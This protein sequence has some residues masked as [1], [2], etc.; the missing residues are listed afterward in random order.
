[1]N[2]DRLCKLAAAQKPAR[3]RA[4]WAGLGRSISVKDRRFAPL[5]KLHHGARVD[6]LRAGSDFQVKRNGEDPRFASGPLPVPANVLRERSSDVLTPGQLAA[7]HSA[8]RARVIIGPSYRADMWAALEREPQLPAAELARRT[9]GSFATA[10]H[11]RRDFV[12]ALEADAG[13]RARGG[14]LRRALGGVR[15]PR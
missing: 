10:W 14:A 9:Y 1:M 11:V 12:I 15:T 7:R 3:V 8:Y 13:K 4:F 2:A 5:G 6:L